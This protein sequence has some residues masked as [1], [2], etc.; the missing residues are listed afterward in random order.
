MKKIIPYGTEAI[1][2]GAFSDDSEITEIELP[3]TVFSIGEEAFYGC[4]AL[5]SVI[6]S[7]GLTEI[8]AAAFAG[9]ESLKEITLP[10]ALVRISDGAFLGCSSL[11]SVTFPSG[12]KELGD[13]AFW[14]SGLI[15]AD[16]P[17][18]VSYIGERCFW[19]CKDL[20]SVFIPNK[21]TIIGDAAFGECESLMSGFIAPG[22]CGKTDNASLLQYT[23]LWCTSIGLHDEAVSVKASDYIRAN[24]SLVME[25]IL[26]RNIIP[27]MTG[28]ARL[29]LLKPENVRKYV[30]EASAKNEREITALLLGMLK[31]AKYTDTEF[32]L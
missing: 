30:S 18:N 14:G 2:D 16:L 1:G 9:C 11:R 17:A 27:A 23:L 12:L 7:R 26:K 31:D 25:H 8:S 21:D 4:T 13:M 3:D 5:R 19:E 32:D 28:I 6:L 22:Y 20:I 24:E 10:E 15:S 29:G